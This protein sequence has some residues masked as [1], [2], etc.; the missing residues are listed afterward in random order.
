MICFKMGFIVHDVHHPSKY[1]NWEF[2]PNGA[3]KVNVSGYHD[4]IISNSTRE[5]LIQGSSGKS[6]K[7]FYYNLGE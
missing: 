3:H 2:M 1:T 7:G 4:W 5:G 6:F